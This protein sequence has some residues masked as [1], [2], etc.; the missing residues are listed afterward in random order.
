MARTHSESHDID[1]LNENILHIDLDDLEIEAME[2][3]VE[4]TLAS[5]FGDLFEVPP[6][7]DEPCG[8]FSCSGYFPVR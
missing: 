5:M 1:S 7:T 4:L 8:S 2:Q 3:R 6:G